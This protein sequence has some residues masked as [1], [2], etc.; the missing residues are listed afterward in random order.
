MSAHGPFVWHELMVPDPSSAPSFY[1]PVTGWNTQKFDGGMDY[2]M[3]VNDEA[4]VGGLMALPGELAAVGV[5]PHW[6]HYIGVNDVDA[7]AAQAEGLGGHVNLPPTDIPDVGRFAVIADPQGAVF[8]IYKSAVNDESPGKPRF[9]EFSWHE[10]GTTDRESAWGF[11]SQLFGWRETSTMDMGGGMLYQMFGVG[12]E[13]PIGGIY[14]I[15]PDM[16]GMPPNWMGYVLVKNVDDA[17][18]AVKQGGG[19]VLNGPMD[20]PGGRIAVFADPQGAAFAAHE[21]AAS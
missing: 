18:S 8:A 13:D 15:T 3:W 1:S 14:K 10:L 20:I 2:T 7:T 12:G 11:Y 21:A 9:G 19:Q 16:E 6:L 5:P 4:P 17:I